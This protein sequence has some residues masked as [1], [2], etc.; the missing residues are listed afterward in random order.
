ML[1][2][3]DINKSVYSFHPGV[4]LVLGE[5]DHGPDKSSR[6][7]EAATIQMLGAI[8]RGP[9]SLHHTGKV[10]TGHWLYMKKRDQWLGVEVPQNT[11]NLSLRVATTSNGL[12]KASLSRALHQSMFIG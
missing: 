1:L 2:F 11:H 9:F 4:Q 7:K 8:V 6:G 3:T 12:F 5:L 10:T